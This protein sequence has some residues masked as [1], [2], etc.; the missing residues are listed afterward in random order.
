M[1]N[2]YVVESCDAYEI[3]CNN[4]GNPDRLQNAVWHMRIASWEIKLIIT[5]SGYEIYFL[6]PSATM[7]VSNWPCY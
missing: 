4:I 2:P 6:F 5:H 1:C 3:T 7:V